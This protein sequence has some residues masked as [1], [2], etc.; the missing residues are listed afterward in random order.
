[1]CGKTDVLEQQV[2]QYQD[3]I[4]GLEAQKRGARN[5]LV[6]L[7]DEIT[8]V[9]HLLNQGFERKPRLLELQ[10]R[11][12]ELEGKEGEYVSDI[13]VAK[14]NIARSQ[15]EILNI[16]N[17][18]LKEVMTELKEVQQTV[19]DLEEKLRASGDVLE[20]TVIRAPQ[21]GKITGLKFHTT[22]GVITP[23]QAIMDIIPQDD[24]LII[25]AHVQP[26]DI[27]VVHEGLSAKVMLSAYRSR[28]V[29]RLEG[30]VTYVSADTFTNEKTGQSYYLARIAIQDGALAKL[31]AH[32]ELYPG[33]PA[34]TFI[35]V[36]KSTLLDYL[37]SPLISSFHRAFKEQ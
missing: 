36:G 25:E 16:Q 21:A 7:K 32:V 34:E 12:A 28:Y 37:L 18:D 33:M 30:K 4:I 24:T 6:L 5:Q 10:R 22:G 26:Q 14:S 9:Q 1:L 35:T 29:P 8:S 3:Q 31:T 23:G 19:D 13:A 17:E 27:D 2:L 20:R 15:L 11:A